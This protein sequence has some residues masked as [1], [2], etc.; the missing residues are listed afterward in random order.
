[1]PGETR[2]RGRESA[3]RDERGPPPAHDAEVRALT[4]EPT[5]IRTGANTFHPGGSR[6]ASDANRLVSRTLVIIRASMSESTPEAHSSQEGGGGTGE[7]EREGGREM[8]AIRCRGGGYPLVRSVLSVVS[9]A[10]VSFPPSPRR[11]LIWV[12]VLTASGQPG[13]GLPTN[14]SFLTPH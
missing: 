11:V 13:R 14:R 3:G 5:E 6:G 9:E 1:M 8:G 12:R 4:Q 7:G 2:E 10:S